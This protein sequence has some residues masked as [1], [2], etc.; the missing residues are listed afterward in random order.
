[1]TSPAPLRWVFADGFAHLLADDGAADPASYLALCGLIV[2]GTTPVYGV[3]PSLEVCRLC[4][5]R[6]WQGV[7]APVFDVEAPTFLPDRLAFIAT[8][9]WW[10]AVA[11]RCRDNAMED[12]RVASN[13][14]SPASS[15]GAGCV[16]GGRVT[17]IVDQRAGSLRL[18]AGG[19][20]MTVGRR[21]ATSS[22][23]AP[24]PGP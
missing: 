6:Q 15:S 8:A 22:R 21:A 3:A 24:D 13:G 12:G 18:A 9:A 4:Q 2:P 19:L 5:R 10:G 1:M 14:R 17:H 16:R 23:P 7:T 20:A 11:D